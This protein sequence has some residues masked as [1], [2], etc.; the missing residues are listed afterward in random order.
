[1]LRGVSQAPD[2]VMDALDHTLAAVEAAP[3]TPLSRWT[4]LFHDSG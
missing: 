2:H 3:D 4:V 1:M